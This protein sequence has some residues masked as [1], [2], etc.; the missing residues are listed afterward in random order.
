MALE[1][2]S[3]AVVTPVASVVELPLEPFP[4]SSSVSPEPPQQTSEIHFS[5]NL[6]IFK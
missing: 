5:L 6:K 4:V 1:S 3:L 2:V